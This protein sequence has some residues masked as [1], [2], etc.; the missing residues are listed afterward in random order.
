MVYSHIQFE[1]I[2]PHT[3]ASKSEN[4]NRNILKKAIMRVMRVIDHF[5]YLNINNN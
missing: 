3:H 2:F 4:N 1:T 5:M